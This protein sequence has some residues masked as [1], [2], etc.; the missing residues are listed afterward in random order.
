MP[1]L[2]AFVVAGPQL[3]PQL[4]AKLVGTGGAARLDGG[5]RVLEHAVD[6]GGP[7]LPVRVQFED[8]LAVA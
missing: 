2:T 5:G 6:R 3:G 8:A 7:F 4:G 1:Q